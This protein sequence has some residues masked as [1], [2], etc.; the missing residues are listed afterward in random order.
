[1]NALI[2]IVITI[3]SLVFFIERLFL[4]RGEDLFGFVLRESAA[5]ASGGVLPVTARSERKHRGE[6]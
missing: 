3:Q 6:V 1:M 2:I 5:E 4:R